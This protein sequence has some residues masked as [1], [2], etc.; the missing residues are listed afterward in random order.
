M[1]ADSWHLPQVLRNWISKAMLYFIYIY[2]ICYISQSRNM[3]LAIESLTI[4]AYWSIREGNKHPIYYRNLSPKHITS[5]RTYIESNKHAVG[6]NLLKMKHACFMFSRVIQQMF[7]IR[8]QTCVL[9][10]PIKGFLPWGSMTE[11]QHSA[12]RNNFNVFVKASKIW[13][14]VYFFISR[15]FLD[16]FSLHLFPS[17][18]LLLSR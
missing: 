10:Y 7:Q 6:N 16:A 2:F 8:K 3:V 13:K 4:L 11:I 9:I 14:E 15:A 17:I 12:S 18:S 5:K 1:R